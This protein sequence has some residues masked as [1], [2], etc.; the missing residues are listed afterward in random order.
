MGSLFRRIL[1]NLLAGG[2]EV[3]PENYYGN[4]DRMLSCPMDAE[5]LTGK[6][7]GEPQHAR[8]ATGN[9][10]TQMVAPAIRQP[11]ILPTE[12]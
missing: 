4:L 5:W 8:R 9:V 2:L 10:G 6:G 11:G 7:L 1:G 3:Q 12:D